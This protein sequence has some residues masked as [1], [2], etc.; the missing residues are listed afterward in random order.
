MSS[1]IY[2][3]TAFVFD[4]YLGTLFGGS[5]VG[6]NFS[7][8]SNIMLITLILI[9]YKQDLIKS[10]LLGLVVGLVF[11]AFNIDT[12]FMFAIIYMVTTWA[13]SAWSTRINDTFIE[14]FLVTL[15]AIF[16]K[17]FFVY[18]AY[19]FLKGYRLSFG[20]WGASHLFFTLLLALLPT[21]VAVLFKINLL[22]KNTR[23]QQ[24]NMKWDKT[25]KR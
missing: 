8:N 11:D 19:V 13:V 24:R 7:A 6:L 23:Q 22:D 5:F 9:T 2:L 20:S 15:S 21:V 3:F 10:M 14:I 17:E 18:L 12:V 4:V 1:F 16:L 25:I